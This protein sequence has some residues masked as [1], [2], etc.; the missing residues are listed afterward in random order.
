M[1]SEPLA[2]IPAVVKDLEE[3]PESHRR[4]YT[5]AEDGTFVLDGG[6]VYRALQRQQDEAKKWKEQ[7]ERFK[8]FDPEELKKLK[9]A[10]ELADRERD[11]E[12]RNFEKVQKEDQDKWQGVVAEKDEQIKKLQL[13]L[14]SALI[15]NDLTREIVAKGASPKPILPALRDQLKLMEVDGKTVAV[16]VDEKG[17]PRLKPE[18]KHI[19]DYMGAAELVDEN[20]SD[21]EFAPL[22]KGTGSTGSGA[23]ISKLSALLSPPTAD[24][25]VEKIQAQ[26]KLGMTG[27]LKP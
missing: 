14:Q 4:L 17:Q 8:D 9:A 13:G 2:A 6:G 12:L 25:E 1:A 19:N 16:A 27:R 23:P 10:K 11:I 21:P 3:A 5:E 7:A 22:Y 18:A 15:D 24:S 26:V 20:K